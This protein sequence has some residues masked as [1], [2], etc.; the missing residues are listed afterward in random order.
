MD[1]DS[2]LSAQL[3]PLEGAL[4]SN[5]RERAAAAL[6]DA[7]SRA[8]S[9]KADGESRAKKLLEDAEEEGRRVAE[10]ESVQRRVEARRKARAMVLS[11]ERAAYRR[12]MDEAANEAR[13]LRDRPEYAALEARLVETAKSLLGTDAEIARNPEGNGGVQGR[14]GS[15]SV[16]LTLT[17][18]A[19]RCAE[20]LGERVTRLWA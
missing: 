4:L 15:R 16:D 12:L 3:G 2:G 10:H 13:S 9:T 17:T 20:G 14:N 6:H 5:A 1:R 19:R 8:S 18:L 11:A 7:E